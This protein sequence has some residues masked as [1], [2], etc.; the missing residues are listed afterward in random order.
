ARRERRTG[1][2]RRRQDKENRRQDAPPRSR[3][4]QSARRARNR[5]PEL[6]AVPPFCATNRPLAAFKNYV[7]RR[8]HTSFR[9]RTS[10]RIAAL[11]S[12]VAENTAKNRVD[13]SKMKLEVELIDKLGFVQMLAHV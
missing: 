8:R 10:R 13:M 2:R 1:R 4:R 11:S 12:G 5:T 9:R 6:S 7:T 3:D